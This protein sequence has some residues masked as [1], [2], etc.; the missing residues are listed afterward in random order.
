MKKREREREKNKQNKTVISLD[1][2]DLIGDIMAI[3]L[4]SL[5]LSLARWVVI[6]IQI[7]LQ[8]NSDKTFNQPSLRRSITKS[9]SNGCTFRESLSHG[10]STRKQLKEREREKKQNKKNIAAHCHFYSGTER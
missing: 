7:E 3:C 4:S 5:S 2:D 1:D 10:P 9:F 8:T 6:I